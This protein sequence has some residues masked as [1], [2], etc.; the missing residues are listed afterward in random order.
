MSYDS[1][2]VFAKILR[3]ELPAQKVYEDT[4]TLAFMDIMPR[5]EGH[6]LVIPKGPVRNILDAS[7]SQLAADPCASRAPAAAAPS[8]TETRGRIPSRRIVS[9]ILASTPS[10]DL[11]KPILPRPSWLVASIPRIGIS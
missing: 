7:P 10:G 11:D 4:D 8:S 6:T 2:N 1:N 9:Q 3:G 5:C